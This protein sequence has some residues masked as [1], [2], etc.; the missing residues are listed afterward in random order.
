M[1]AA[2]I[3]AIRDESGDLRGRC[4][5][6]RDHSR[7]LRLRSRQSRIRISRAA[8]GMDNAAASLSAG[9]ETDGV[10]HMD[11]LVRAESDLKSA[12]AECSAALV[13]VRRELE[14]RDIASAA[15][16]H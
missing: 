2:I 7:T 13:E 11:R 15:I 8:E 3:S 16:V 4:G 1:K 5:R 12:I 10:A 9:L 6:L 14:W